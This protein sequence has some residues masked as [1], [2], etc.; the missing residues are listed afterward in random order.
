MSKGNEKR[1]AKRPRNGLRGHGCVYVNNG[2][3]YVSVR[4]TGELKPLCAPGSDRPKP[5]PTNV[6]TLP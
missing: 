1:A 2:C 5:R 3:W 4:L 6:R